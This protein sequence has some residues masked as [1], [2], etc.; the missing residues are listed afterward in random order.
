M[1]AD[2]T[3]AALFAHHG[4]KLMLTQNG[5]D[6]VPMVPRLLEPWQHPAPLQ[7]IGHAALPVPNVDDHLIEHVIAALEGS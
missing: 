4:V 5:E 2:G 1:S 7:H 6:I 3:L